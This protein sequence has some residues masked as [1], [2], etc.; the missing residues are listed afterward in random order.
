MSNR[1]PN[2]HRKAQRG[3]PECVRFELGGAQ[4]G[5]GDRCGPLRRPPFIYPYF[6]VLRTAC[7]IGASLRIAGMSA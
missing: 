7:E 3:N 5:A 6:G 1:I 2:F 4:G